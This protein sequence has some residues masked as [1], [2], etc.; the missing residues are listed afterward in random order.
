MGGAVSVDNLVKENE[1]DKAEGDRTW[2][3]ERQYF[4]KAPLTLK[5]DR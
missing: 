4:L 3:D 1:V 2:A 5:E